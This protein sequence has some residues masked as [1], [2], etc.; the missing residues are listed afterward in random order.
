M[1]PNE[2]RYKCQVS[3][4]GFGEEKQQLLRQARVLII[5]AGGLGCPAAQY[6]AAMGIGVLGIADD[7]VV[8]VSNLHRQILYTLADAGLKKAEVASLRLKA[9]NPEVDVIC[10][11][12]RITDE[13]VLDIIG[14]YDIVLD[15][16]D[17]FDTRYLVNDACVFSGKPVIYG[18]IYQYEG[19]LAVWNTRLA[20]GT[21]SP[22]YRDVYPSVNAT[23]IPNCTDGGVLPT[24]AGIIGCMMANEAAKVITGAG[25]VLAGNVLLFDARY[26]QSRS[27]KVNKTTDSQV[28][29]P[30]KSV[31]VP[32]I[33]HRKLR[34]NMSNYLLIDVRD[35]DE[36]NT[37]NIGGMN[38]ALSNIHM[39]ADYL[40]DNTPVVFYCHSGA[41]SA[42]AIKV[43]KPLF[44]TE[45][46]SLEGGIKNW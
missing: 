31:S 46:Y 39:A 29:R 15:C 4:P 30:P 41:R 20:D 36:H 14:D 1:Q 28:K 9:Q 8:S 24:L 19:Q 38:I 35:E 23:M 34:D 44:A 3:L 40:L 6:L 42:E 12:V 18:A 26:M 33:S 7:D 17:N 5:G 37:F 27:I 10:H 16:S 22:N 21:F 25:D 13:Q 43:L 2:S 32:L 45:M 11:P